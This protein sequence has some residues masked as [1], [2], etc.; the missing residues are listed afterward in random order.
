MAS[1][2]DSP[3]FSLSFAGE[4]F[5]VVGLHPKASRPARRFSSPALVFNLHAQFEELR[6]AGRYEK[7]RPSILQRDEVLA[8]SA[9]PMLARHGEVSEARQYSGRAVDEG[10]RCPFKPRKANGEVPVVR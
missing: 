10:W 7:L 2:P 8:G 5:F 3:H 1:E 4:A 6:E 9:N